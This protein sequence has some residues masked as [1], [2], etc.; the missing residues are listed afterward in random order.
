MAKIKKAQAGTALDAY[1][2]A[3][4]K[5][6]VN[7]KAD[8]TYTKSS[9]KTADS[10]RSAFPKVD[11]KGG[12]T[13]FLEER[14]ANKAKADSIEGAVEKRIGVPRKLN[15]YSQKNGGVTK[16]AQAGKKVKGFGDHTNKMAKALDKASVLGKNYIAPGDSAKKTVK[17]LVSKKKMGGVVKAQKGKKITPTPDSTYF[18]EKRA[19][20]YD[21]A[22][23]RLIRA[24]GYES[25]MRTKKMAD[26]ARDD[27]YRQGLK[28]TPGYDA[29]G[30]PIKKTAVKK[31]VSKKKNGGT[32]SSQLGSYKGVI[33]KN[34][35]GKATKAVGLV[36]ANYGKSM[37]KCKYGC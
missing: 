36:K 23:G 10:L 5:S 1:K 37:G 24:G 26:Q 34:T 9:F 2:K 4:K 17:K 11:P 6:A 31:A 27:A 12:L 14:K 22:A 25:V 29:N 15:M 20:K 28:G 30:F 16:K 7:A 18:F 21:K 33:G 19:D 8:A 32:V 35:K 3:S 13:K